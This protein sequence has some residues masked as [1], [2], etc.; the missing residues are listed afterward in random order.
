MVLQIYITLYL[1]LKKAV[2]LLMQNKHSFRSYG[3]TAAYQTHQ[4]IVRQAFFFI[5]TVLEAMPTTAFQIKYAPYI[6]KIRLRLQR[7]L[8]CF[9]SIKIARYEP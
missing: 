6:K 9:Y 5:S 1:A 8:K 7:Q 2:I 4:A 3:L